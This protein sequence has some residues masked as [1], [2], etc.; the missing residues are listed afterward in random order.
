MAL[1]EYSIASLWAKT[2]DTYSPRQI[3]F[4]GT[5]AVQ[6]LFF[7]VP[8]LSFLALDSLFPAFSARHKIQPAAKQPTRAEITHCAVVV[9][10]NQ[11]QSVA[12]ALPVPFRMPPTLPTAA[13][14]ARDLPL[15][16]LAREVAF[17]YTHRLL[18][19]RALYRAVHK[20]HH[21]FTAP[22]ALAAQYAHP[23]EQLL[24]NTL[25]IVLPP[26][27]L[28]THVVT[29]WLFL[30]AMLLETATVHSGYDFFGGVARAHD[31]HH[32]RFSVH[33]G[34]YG[35]MDWLHGTG[36]QERGR[37]KEE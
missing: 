26:L 27:A 21:E 35:W 33:F 15:C 32:E 22:V 10:R 9:L 17:Y 1:L 28:R 30:A 19:T 18:H 34:A 4:W 31:R 14:L 3:E 2:V 8:A 5:L 23:A 20:T 24:A 29:M 37:V 16:L 7:W 13:E 6:V 11:L 12:S 36:E 25:P